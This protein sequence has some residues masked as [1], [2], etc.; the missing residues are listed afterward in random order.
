METTK[1]PCVGEC[2]SIALGDPICKGC[3]RTAEE[4]RDWNTYDDK[5]KIEINKRVKN[6]STKAN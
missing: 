1:T 5:R 4:V 3:K 6:E 2:M